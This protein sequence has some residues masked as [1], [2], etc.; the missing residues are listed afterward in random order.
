MSPAHGGD[1]LKVGFIGLGHMGASIA[2]R[3]ARAGFDL[4]VFD[5][6]DDAIPP[7]EARGGTRAG[8]AAEL[9]ASVDLLCTCLATDEDVNALFLGSAGILE[10]ARP[11][12][13]CTVHSTVLPQ[14]VIDLAEQARMHDVEIIDAPVSRSD[15]ASDARPGVDV[16]DDAPPLPG[17][18]PALT[19]MV[20]GSETAVARAMPVFEAVGDHVFVLG[21]V[22]MAQVAKIA[23]NIMGISNSVIAMEAVRYADAFG[24]DK[25]KLFEVVSVSAGM[26][27]SVLNYDLYDRLPDEQAS[28]GKTK[29][30]MS[31]GVKDLQHALASAEERSTFLPV[32]ALCSQL[33]P[34]MLADRWRRNAQAAAE[35]RSSG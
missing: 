17:A 8:S 27:W 28:L 7:L 24:L 1:P 19:V 11:G 23:N 25:E 33:F 20:G 18:F 13:V 6:R 10:A 31:T 26:S 3:I 4:G 16:E 30:P 14:T 15:F 29:A 5:L 21:D 35:D 2:A 32:V 9:A 22:G 12:L 34:T